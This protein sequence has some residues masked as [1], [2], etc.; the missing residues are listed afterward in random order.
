MSESIAVLG[1]KGMLGTALSHYLKKNGYAVSVWDRPDFDITQSSDLDN[2]LDSVQVV[3]NCAAF[4]DVDGAEDQPETAMAV[5]AESVGALGRL[6]KQKNL[7]VVH[8]STDFVFDGQSERPYKETDKTHPLSVY[9]DSKLKGELILER[10][11]CLY[12]IMRVQWTFGRQGNH[13]I[14]KLLKRAKTG[15]DL[16]IVN[17]QIGA[18]TWSVDMA[19]AILCL[20]R[21]RYAGLYH[22]TC[23]GYASRYDVACFVAK[24]LGL[25]NIITPCL[26]SEFPVKAIRPKNSR[27]D[28]TKIQAVLDHPIRRWQ[29]AL[30]EFLNQSDAEHSQTLSPISFPPIGEHV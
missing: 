12:S 30:S 6:A 23:Q 7:F 9:G 2:A 26:S 24:E 19:K 13:F 28:T 4:T 21:G 17:D 16:K 25:K 29:D 5:N 1:G 10:T 8:V 27:F 15:A 3:V 18:P 11:G 22:F 14:A 20:I